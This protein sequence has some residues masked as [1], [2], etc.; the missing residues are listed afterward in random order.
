[1][2]QEQLAKKA[3]YTDKGMIAKIENGLVDLRVSKL[4]RFAEIFGVTPGTLI[5]EDE[6]YENVPALISVAETNPEY[7]ELVETVRNAT[8][9]EIRTTTKVLKA[10]SED[11]DQ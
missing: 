9:E 8:P 5:G 10:L 1:M 6:S 4:L 3:G 7:N 2:T 11:D